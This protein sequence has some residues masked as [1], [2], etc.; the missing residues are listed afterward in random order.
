M[1]YVFGTDGIVEANWER[2]TKYLKNHCYLKSSNINE[3]CGDI[4]ILM[5]SGLDKMTYNKKLSQM[6]IEGRQL[7]TEIWRQKARVKRISVHKQDCIF[8]KI[9]KYKRLQSISG[10]K[11]KYYYKQWEKRNGCYAVYYEIDKI[12]LI[13]RARNIHHVHF[14]CT[15]LAML[16]NR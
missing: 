10:D 8:D 4:F 11:I 1:V 6:Q 12:N 7:L 3:C 15:S 14:C 5:L 16:L 13:D 2:I 9:I